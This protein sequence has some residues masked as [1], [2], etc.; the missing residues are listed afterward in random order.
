M[1]HPLSSGHYAKQLATLHYGI[2]QC[3]GL[4][5]PKYKESLE[6]NIRHTDYLTE[7]QKLAVLNLLEEL[8]EGDSLCHGDFHPGNIMKDGDDVYI[9]DW[10]TAAVGSPAADVARTVLLLKDSALPGHI[11]QPVKFLIGCMRKSMAAAYLKQYLKLSGL[12][13]E[14]VGSWRTVIIAARLREWIPESEKKAMLKE[15]EIAIRQ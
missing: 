10:M 12:Q 6:W 14:E 15:I 4:E 8:S 1:K 5:L 2:H 11:P 13:K 3:R 9:L 7:D